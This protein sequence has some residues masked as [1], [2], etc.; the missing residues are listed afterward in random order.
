MR[1]VPQGVSPTGIIAPSMRN[2]TVQRSLQWQ[3]RQSASSVMVPA[4]LIRKRLHRRAHTGNTDY[5]QQVR[6]LTIRAG[7]GLNEMKALRRPDPQ[8]GPIVRSRARTPA[9]SY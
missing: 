3:R 5:G 4:P 9:M 8:R 2:S 6:E 7:Q 1:R